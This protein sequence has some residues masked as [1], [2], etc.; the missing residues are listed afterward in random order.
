MTYPCTAQTEKEQIEFE[1]EWKELGR[2]LEEDRKRQDFLARERQRL[3]QLEQRGEM[4][5]E[6]EKELKKMVTKGHWGLAKD[7]ASIHMGLEK[8]QTFEEAFAK[9]QASTGISDIEQLV[10]MFIENEDRVCAHSQIS[11]IGECWGRCAETRRESSDT[12]GRNWVRFW[13]SRPSHVCF[14]E[15]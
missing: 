5:V 3:L 4:S 12:W 2:K 13:L 8:V 7:K 15:L 14:A 10:Q 9:I 11:H 1:A 6:D